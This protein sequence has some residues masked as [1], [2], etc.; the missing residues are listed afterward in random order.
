MSNCKTNKESD[1]YKIYAKNVLI[2]GL[3]YN[4]I[5]EWKL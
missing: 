3:V 4:W 5:S 1:I 2:T